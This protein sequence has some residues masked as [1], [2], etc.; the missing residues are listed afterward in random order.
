MKKLYG[1]KLFIQARLSWFHISRIIWRMGNIYV[2][3]CT[4]NHHIFEIKVSMFTKMTNFSRKKRANLGKN[5]WRH[6]KYVLNKFS[7]RNSLLLVALTTHQSNVKDK[8]EKK[9]NCCFREIKYFRYT[10]KHC[11]P[12]PQLDHYWLTSYLAS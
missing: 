3:S 1:F 6:R 9:L 5:I 12:L 7:Q 11:V 8:Y 10:F 2:K 4:L